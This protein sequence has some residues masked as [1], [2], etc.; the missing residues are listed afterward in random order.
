MNIKSALLWVATG[1]MLAACQSSSYKICGTAEGQED[2]DTLFL[3][4]DLTNGIP[5]D[6]TLVSDGK[7][8]F[9][10][11]ADSLTL[12]MVYS[13]RRNEVNANFFLEPGEINVNISEQPGASRVGGTE[14][15]DK[16]QELVDSVMAIGKRINLIAEHIYGNTVSEEEQAKGM[17]QIEKLNQHFADVLKEKARKNIKNEFGYFLLTYYPEEVLDNQTRL[18]LIGQLPDNMRNRDAVKQLEEYIK[19]KSMTA[20]GTTLPDFSQP[21]P[22]GTVISIKEEI[23][24]HK[25]T[26][27]DFWASWCGPCRQEMPNVV[28]AYQRYHAAKG[29]EIVGVSFD[30]KAESWKKA[31]KDLG[32]DWPQM[33]DL[34]GWNS[35]AHTA[36]GVNSI[37]SNVLLDPQGKIVASDL[38]GTALAAKLKEIYQ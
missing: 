8:T 24:K 28:E 14:C 5:C 3:T 26:I 4:T 2:G 35:A 18:E 11:K 30:S 25:I 37:P 34:K 22:D 33:S 10:G 36:Y 38:R 31:V 12:A 1:C 19:K 27:I 16:W 29:F 20:E 13:A 21:A 23:G 7:F 17:E 9:E 6:T 32:M 15:N